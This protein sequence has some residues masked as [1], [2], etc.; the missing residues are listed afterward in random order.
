MAPEVLRSKTYTQAADIYSFVLDI[1]NGI[2]PKIS[3]PEA[4]KCLMKRCWDPNPDNR[5]TAI[6]IH[7]SIKTFHKFYNSYKMS[8]SKAI[9][10][11]NQFKEAE[12]YRKSH[13]SSSNSSK[14]K[15]HTQV[16]YTSRPLNP[17]TKDLPIYDNSE[18]LDCEIT[19]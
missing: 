11:K 5:P 18:C 15:Q 14:N 6:E 10:I 1:C 7:E 2:R 17:Y 16:I 3:E 13:L 8:E 19:C 12:S 9:E 4:P